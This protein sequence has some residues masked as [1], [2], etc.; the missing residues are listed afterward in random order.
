[1]EKQAADVKSIQQEIINQLDNN[2]E[3]KVLTSEIDSENLVWQAQCQFLLTLAQLDIISIY[4]DEGQYTYKVKEVNTLLSE[5]LNSIDPEIVSK[6]Y[7]KIGEDM[8]NPDLDEEKIYF[9]NLVQEIVSELDQEEEYSI[10]AFF[11][12]EDEDWAS[13]ISILTHLQNNGSVSVEF[14]EKHLMFT[15][16]I[17]ERVCDA[18]PEHNDRSWNIIEEENIL[19]KS[20]II[21]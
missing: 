14:C 19:L 17:G 6:M 11:D 12:E 3:F 21:H 10:S 8:L 7:M 13:K 16:R 9:D 20:D 2:R 15:Y 5:I 18:H 4:F 1:M